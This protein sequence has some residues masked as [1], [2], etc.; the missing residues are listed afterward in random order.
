MSD[1]RAQR[2]LDEVAERRKDLSE[3]DKAHIAEVDPLGCGHGCHKDAKGWLAVPWCPV[4]GL[5]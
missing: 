5:R 2:Q 4:H 3:E 1:A